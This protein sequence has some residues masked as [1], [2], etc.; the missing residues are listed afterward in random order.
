[1]GATADPSG[2]QPAAAAT[3]DPVIATRNPRRESL[4]R[5]LY[6]LE[7]MV[8]SSSYGLHQLLKLSRKVVTNT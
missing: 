5:E 4:L 3:A 8:N 1:V 7:G 6:S 2:R